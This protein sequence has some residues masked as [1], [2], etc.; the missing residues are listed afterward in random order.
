MAP[1]GLVPLRWDDVP[2]VAKGFE[3]ARD[4]IVSRLRSLLD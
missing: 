4:A 2:P 1:A 3:A